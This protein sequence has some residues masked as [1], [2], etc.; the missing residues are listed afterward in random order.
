M[1]FTSLDNTFNFKKN[2]TILFLISNLIVFLAYTIN[3]YIN[4]I[5]NKINLILVM[6]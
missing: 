5:I 4:K 3:K 1:W 6:K 2:L